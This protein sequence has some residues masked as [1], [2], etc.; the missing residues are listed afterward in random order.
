MGINA[1]NDEHKAPAARR[2]LWRYLSPRRYLFLATIGGGATFA[3]APNFQA[4]PGNSAGSAGQ[5]DEPSDGARA[6]GGNANTGGDT[7]TGGAPNAASGGAT[8]TNEPCPALR[9]ATEQSIANANCDEIRW[10]DV[11]CQE[12]SAALV[13]VGGGYLRRASYDFDGVPRIITG[14]GAAGHK[15]WGYTVNHF[16]DT[17]TIGQDAAGTFNAIFTGKHHAIYEYKYAPVIAGQTVPVTQHWFF[18]TGR[19]N[20]ILATTYDMTAIQAGSLVA[21]IRTPYGDLAWDGDDSEAVISGVGWGDRRKFRTTSAPL[22]A[23]SSWDY[24]APNT[25]PYVHA[26][27]T[28]RDAEMGV[29]QTQTYRQHDAGGYWFYPNWGKTSE[30]QT[31][32]AEQSTVMTPD[33]NWTY[34]LNQYELCFYG[35]GCSTD[36]PTR[37]H[38]MA[39]GMNYGALG[40][41]TDPN[42]G[43]DQQYVG[44][45]DQDLYSGH[46]YQS[47]SVFLVLGPLSKAATEAQVSE[48]EAV[49][50]TALI[51]TIGTVV[52]RLP[53]GVGRTDMVPL[54]VLGF[55]PR[56]ATWNLEAESGKVELSFRTDLLEHPIFVLRYLVSPT[57]VTL[58]GKL[59]LEDSDYFVSS[60]PEED[61]SYITLR[62]TLRGTNALTFE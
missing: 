12:R 13:R 62:T 22:S 48:I 17:A 56:Y 28:E 34:Q 39:W 49:Q 33:W 9:W 4:E 44:Y 26:W 5:P 54:D 42:T 23:N 30:N 53:G 61:L 20:P 1:S 59:L 51:A 11:E 35:G 8:T 15:G 58:N 16:G 7:A 2:A 38:R 57:R 24:T 32:A 27:V 25:I 55:D 37:S 50:N 47:Y 45:G 41:L 52:A 3:C 19:S 40:G 31:R 6:T 14:T 21:D 60:H 18:A 29:V 10:R 46:P 36:S 43:T